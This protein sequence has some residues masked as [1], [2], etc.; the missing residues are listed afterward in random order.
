M[1]IKLPF[2]KHKQIIVHN[3]ENKATI[4]VI[5]I[6]FFKI[7]VKNFLMLLL[8]VNDGQDHWKAMRLRRRSRFFEIIGRANL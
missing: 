6:R 4:F 8:H 3:E 5:T 7:C 2:P 1:K